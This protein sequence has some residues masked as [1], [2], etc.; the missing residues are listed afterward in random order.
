MVESQQTLSVTKLW[1]WSTLTL[2][3]S[4]EGLLHKCCY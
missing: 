2:L 1:V 3:F 4:L